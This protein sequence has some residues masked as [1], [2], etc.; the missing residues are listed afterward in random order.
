MLTCNDTSML[1]HVRRHDTN[2]QAVHH[3]GRSMANSQLLRM[4]RRNKW[5]AT[6]KI[7]QTTEIHKSNLNS[8][9]ASRVGAKQ[10]RVCCTLR[11][12][13]QRH[14][15]RYRHLLHELFSVIAQQNSR[16]GE[17]LW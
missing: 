4:E 12:I 8:Q 11:L 2:N 9:R 6:E 13:N 15:R 5:D 3:D 10:T 1:G 16:S 14:A 17:P 7:T